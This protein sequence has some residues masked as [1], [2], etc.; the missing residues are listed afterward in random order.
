MNIYCFSGLGADE[1]I[2][3]KLNIPGAKLHFVDW[4]PANK[5]ETLPQYAQRLSNTIRLENPFCMLGVSFGGMI[6]TELS[7][8]LKPKHTFI[9]SSAPNCSEVN[10]LIRLIG[11]TGI[12][13]ILPGSFY[14]YPGFAVHSVFGLKSK[15]EKKLFN[16]IMLYTDIHFLKWAMT[17]ILNWKPIGVP[18]VTRIHGS[19]DWII[20]LNDQ[21]IDHVIDEGAHFCVLQ[22]ANQISE[23]IGSIIT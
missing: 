23:F 3:F 12:H 8:T 16:Q 6:A 7:K 13:K 2:F 19:K 18:E 20:P 11:K 4:I 21:K 1:R 17:A 14:R 9:I 15:P 10:F 5:A 22:Q